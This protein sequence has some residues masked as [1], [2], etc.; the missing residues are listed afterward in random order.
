MKSNLGQLSI[1]HHYL[2]LMLVGY[3]FMSCSKSATDVTPLSKS[4]SSLKPNTMEVKY[5]GSTYTLKYIT[6]AKIVNY[7]SFR[8]LALYGQDQLP[9]E[10]NPMLLIRFDFPLPL[11][12]T[13]KY[14]YAKTADQYYEPRLSLVTFFLQDQSS[15]TNYKKTIVSSGDLVS[16]NGNLE[17]TDLQEG[18]FVQGRFTFDLKDKSGGTAA[19]EGVFNINF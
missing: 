1:A 13:K 12:D 11:P 5:L 17:I 19:A 3:V 15:K 6:N 4:P 2:L 16:A 10:Y 14:S 7:G 8:A 9:L 18:K